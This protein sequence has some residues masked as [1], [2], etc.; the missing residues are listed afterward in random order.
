MH[1]V[2]TSDNNPKGNAHTERVIRPLKEE[3]LWLQEWTSPI[4]LI[5]ALGG[6]VKHYNAHDLHSALGYKMPEQDERQYHN[7]HS[8]P[9]VAA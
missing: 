2:F 3:C 5:R 7:S 4:E 9:F 8:P 6:R 1:Q